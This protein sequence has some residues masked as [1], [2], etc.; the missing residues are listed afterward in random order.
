M[1]SLEGEKIS[2]AGATKPAVPTSR[3]GPVRPE[4]VLRSYAY[5]FR[6]DRPASCDRWKVTRARH[7]SAFVTAC[8]CTH[9]ISGYFFYVANMVDLSSMLHL[10]HLV[11]HEHML[12]LKFFTPFLSC[13][14]S[15]D[16]MITI[17][18][19]KLNITRTVNTGFPCRVKYVNEHRVSLC[20]SLSHIS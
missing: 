19:H 17:M 14:P 15:F 18:K 12:R 3:A 5:H 11:R 20:V 4:P 10:G 9:F 1:H 6:S 13:F 16:I 2:R 7:K 8:A